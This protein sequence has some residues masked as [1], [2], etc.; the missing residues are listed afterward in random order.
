MTA[1][2]VGNLLTGP[3]DSLVTIKTA[4]GSTAS[5][6]RDI[7]TDA[8]A[9]SAK[10]AAGT[11]QQNRSPAMTPSAA[12]I[13]NISGQNNARAVSPKIGN[14][15]AV[16]PR[17]ANMSALSPKAGDASAVS[18]RPANSPPVE[19]NGAVAHRSPATFMPAEDEPAEDV[20][21]ADLDGHGANGVAEIEGQMH[22]HE[23]KVR[24]ILFL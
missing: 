18:P 21:G 17:V 15:G 10:K 1:V 8:A 4:K 13:V 24:R 20:N 11:P 16:S 6:R 23:Q 19:V 14:I 3:Q 12:P 9:K 22:G 5:L 7:L 2:Q